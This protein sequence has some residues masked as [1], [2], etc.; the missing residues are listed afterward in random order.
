MINI[1]RPILAPYC[2]RQ[3]HGDG[4]YFKCDYMCPKC[5]YTS[6]RRSI[7]RRH[8]YKKHT[9]ENICNLE[10][11]DEIRECVLRDRIYHKP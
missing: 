9:C 4:M 10:L 7:M 3:W 8:L 1:S 11:T 2:R 5:E 6:N